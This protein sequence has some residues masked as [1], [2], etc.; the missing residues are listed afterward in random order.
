MAVRLFVGYLFSAQ[1][2]DSLFVDLVSLCWGNAET[3]RRELWVLLEQ[4]P[5]SGHRSFIVRIVPLCQ[6]YWIANVVHQLS[7]LRV[8]VGSCTHHDTMPIVIVDVTV[9]NAHAN[10]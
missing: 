2:N 4:K 9:L 8:V 3:T 1:N 5:T 10:D 6:V 7:N